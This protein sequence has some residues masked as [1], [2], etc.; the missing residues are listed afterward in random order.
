[1]IG[2][3]KGTERVK[4]YNRP[5]MGKFPKEKEYNAPVGKSVSRKGVVPFNTTHFR[6]L[7]SNSPTR[8]IV[9]PSIPRKEPFVLKKFLESIKS[10][11]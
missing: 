7:R 8:R 6:P 9:A 4:A 1:M 3:G 2:P 10:K 5:I 11:K